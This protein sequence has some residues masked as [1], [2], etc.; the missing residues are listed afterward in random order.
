MHKKLKA[1]GGATGLFV[2]ALGVTIIA[3]PMR[4]KNSHG[5]MIIDGTVTQIFS[6][7]QGNL[8]NVWLTQT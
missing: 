3:L 2:V 4:Q 8:S 7:Y 1:W 6:T 5:T